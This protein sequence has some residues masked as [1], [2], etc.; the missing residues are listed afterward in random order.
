MSLLTGRLVKGSWEGIC[1][2]LQI[3]PLPDD[4]AEMKELVKSTHVNLSD[5]LDSGRSGTEIPI[6]QT[7]GELAEYTIE[8]VRFF[9]KLEAYAGGV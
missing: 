3:D 9:P 6:F 4:V 5:L 2:L 1:S 7:A 8:E